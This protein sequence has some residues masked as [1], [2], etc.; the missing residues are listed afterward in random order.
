MVLLATATVARIAS[1]LNPGPVKIPATYLNTN[2]TLLPG[3][4]MNA[5]NL[6]DFVGT[7]D[8]LNPVVLLGNFYNGGDGPNYGAAFSD[9]AMVGVDS[10]L[11]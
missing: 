5:L 4:A 2:G 10:D 6:L 9:N 7:C 3:Q 11:Y 8:E 1:V